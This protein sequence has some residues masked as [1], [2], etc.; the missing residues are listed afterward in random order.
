MHAKHPA[1]I[2]FIFRGFYNLAYL[3]SYSY[4]L[5]RGEITFIAVR[6]ITGEAF[7]IFNITSELNYFDTLLC[8]KLTSNIHASYVSRQSQHLRAP[9]MPIA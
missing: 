1:E 9:S 6:K 5:K 8:G 2:S 3:M 4:S 7:P